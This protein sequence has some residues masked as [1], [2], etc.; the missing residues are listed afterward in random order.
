MKTWYKQTGDKKIV[1]KNFKCIACKKEVEHVM[2]II[3]VG[4]PEL[5]IFEYRTICSSCG[6]MR[7]LPREPC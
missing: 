6:S 2:Q 5:P 4:T 3:L 1:K 7:R